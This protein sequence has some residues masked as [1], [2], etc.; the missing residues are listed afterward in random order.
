MFHLLL[1][2]RCLSNSHTQTHTHPLAH[3]STHKLYL[4][5]WESFFNLTTRTVTKT[6]A[7]LLWI[8]YWNNNNK[9][10]NWFCVLQCNAVRSSSSVWQSVKHK[11][12]TKTKTKEEDL[13]IKIESSFLSYYFSKHFCIW[14]LLLF[15]MCNRK[16]QLQLQQ[17]LLLNNNKTHQS[18]IIKTLI[19]F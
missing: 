3:T 4:H 8:I 17:Q 14:F 11:Q 1:I 15:L 12:R 10:S 7:K 6:V 5:S 19:Q 18:I 16:Q 2:A 13:V 9:S